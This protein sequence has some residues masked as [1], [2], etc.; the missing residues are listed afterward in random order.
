MSVVLVHVTQIITKYLS[1]DV[2]TASHWDSHISL[3]PE[4]VEQLLFWKSNV[5]LINCRNIFQNQKV[6]KIVYSDVSC[7]GYAG[8]EVSTL[9]GVSHGN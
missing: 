5:I 6:S 9:N 1:A 8:Y 2:L 7:T 4:S 3:S